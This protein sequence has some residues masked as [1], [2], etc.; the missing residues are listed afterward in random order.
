[1]SMFGGSS[2]LLGQPGL[3]EAL[4][5]AVPPGSVG[6]VGEVVTA[7]QREPVASE[8]KLSQ[9]GARFGAERVPMETEI[10]PD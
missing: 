7:E 8:A 6:E 2:L 3:G 1:M 10:S 9:S 4:G 5:G